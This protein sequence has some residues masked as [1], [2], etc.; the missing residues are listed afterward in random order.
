MLSRACLAILFVICLSCDNYHNV[1]VDA[2]KSGGKVGSA[3]LPRKKSKGSTLAKATGFMGS[4][5][6][7][8]MFR[9]LKIS[10]CSEL[11]AATL[12]PREAGRWARSLYHGKSL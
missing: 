9:E 11:E 4:G 10:F 1:A 8:R 6:M 12:Q 2:A 3:A 5:V 7:N